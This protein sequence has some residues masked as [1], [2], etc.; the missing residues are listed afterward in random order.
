MNKYRVTKYDPKNR[1]KEGHYMYDHWTELG[2]VGKTLEGELVTPDA[3]LKVEED[4]VKAVID[5]LNV[6][7]QTHLRLIGFDEKLFK[8]FLKENKKEWFHDASFENIVLSEDLKIGIND[9]PTIIRLNLRNYLHATLE[10][11]DRY[12][13]HFGYDFYMYVGAPKLSQKTIDK[14]NESN[15]F[16]EEF[17]SPYYSPE[18]EYVVQR[19][20]KGSMFIADEYILEGISIDEMK[21]IFN[22]SEEHTGQVNTIIDK[23][24]ADKLEIKTDFGKYEYYLTTE[25][26]I[27]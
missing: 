1:N 12:Y 8:G 2:D 13:V 15:V 6:S 25:L 24:L 7:N 16:I 14:I 18:L 27:E 4:Y 10:I 3:Y 19:S 5:I 9:I 11:K 20:E 26:K 22:L 21:N 17:W 23:E